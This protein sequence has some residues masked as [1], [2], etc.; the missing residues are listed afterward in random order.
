MKPFNYIASRLIGF[1]LILLI[2]SIIYQFTIYPSIKKSEGWLQHLAVRQL[3]KNAEILY[4]SSSTNKAFGPTDTDQ[5]SI[6]QIVQ[7]SIQHNIVSID[8]GAIHCGIFYEI[9][10]RI[11]QNQLPKKSS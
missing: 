9:L 10:K 1:V 6:V 4:L 2:G 8:T 5:R 11:P 3:E 7:D